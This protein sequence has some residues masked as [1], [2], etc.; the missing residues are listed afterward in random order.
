MT[1]TKNSKNIAAPSNPKPPNSSSSDY[2]SRRHQS[3]SAPLC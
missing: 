2:A 1:T 3:A